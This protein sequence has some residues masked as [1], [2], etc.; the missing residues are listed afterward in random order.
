MNTIENIDAFIQMHSFVFFLPPFG[1]VLYLVHFRNGIDLIYAC[2]IDLPQ[3]TY[4]FPG[5]HTHTHTHRMTKSSFSRGR[6]VVFGYY[7]AT[8]GVMHHRGN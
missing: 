8:L 7:V 2:S 5:T 4:L 6:I 3:A 1:H